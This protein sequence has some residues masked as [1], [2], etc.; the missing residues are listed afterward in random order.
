[1]IAIVGIFVVLGC[2]VGG[3]LLEGGHLGI[4]IQPIEALIIGGAALGSFLIASPMSVVKD[5]FSH[6]LK[7]FTAKEKSKKD[8]LELLSVM[9]GL[10]SEARRG[11]AVAMDQHINKPDQSKIFTKYPGVLKD[12]AVTRFLCDNLKVV[13]SGNIEHHFMDALMDFDISTRHHHHLIPSQS[14]TK[15]ADSLPGLGIVAAVLG[16]V[17]TM[18]KLDQ[19]PEVLGHSIGSAL[20]GTFLGVLLCY[21]F[22]G[23]MASSLEHMAAA[24]QTQLKVV[25]S[26]LSAYLMGLAPILAVEAGRRA[27]PGH[28]QPTFEEL[29]EAMKGA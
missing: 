1:M 26:A 23:P 11:G 15:I 3:F 20:L 29:E 16:V 9:F 17:L 27:I 8:Y 7:I 10:F 13:L 14:V 4:L 25:K 6:I 5:V 19:P 24:K 28:V 18:G 2:V 21:G 12:K 22:V